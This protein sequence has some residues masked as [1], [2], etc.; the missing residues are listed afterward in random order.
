MPT[1]LGVKKKIPDKWVVVGMVWLI[2]CL[3]YTDRM[4]IFFNLPRVP[5]RHNT[6]SDRFFFAVALFLL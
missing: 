5:F 2:A 6:G 4:T 3:N 1:V